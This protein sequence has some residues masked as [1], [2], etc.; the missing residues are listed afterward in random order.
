MMSIRLT[1]TKQLCVLKTLSETKKGKEVF[2]L[3]V[4]IKIRL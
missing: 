1:G 2:N 3:L 4:S